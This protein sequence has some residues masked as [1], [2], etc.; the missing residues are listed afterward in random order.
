MAVLT[1]LERQTQLQTLLATTNSKRRP[2]FTHLSADNSWLLSIPIADDTPAATKHGTTHRHPKVYFHI[3]LDAWLTP[4]NVPFPG[5]RWF[6]EQYDVEP[7]ACQSIAAIL[8]L[9]S[10]IEAA[11][12]GDTNLD[13]GGKWGLMQ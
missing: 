9:I 2:L 12:S 3:L 13:G 7:P 8:D 4:S 10:D 1:G 11:T 5:A 6:Q